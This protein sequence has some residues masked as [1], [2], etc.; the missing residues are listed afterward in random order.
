[1]CLRCA[2]SLSIAEP[3]HHP[4]SCSHVEPHDVTDRIADLNADIRANISARLRDQPAIL[5]RVRRSSQCL[6]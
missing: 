6:L 5:H 3:N 2:H 1:M 4:H